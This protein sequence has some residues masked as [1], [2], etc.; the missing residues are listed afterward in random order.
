[1]LGVG[2]GGTHQTHALDSHC[3]LTWATAVL[4]GSPGRGCSV[5][6][7]NWASRDPGRKPRETAQVCSCLLS[8]SWGSY[9]GCRSSTTPSSQMEWNNSVHK[10]VLFYIFLWRRYIISMFSN[11]QVTEK[12]RLRTT[13]CQLWEGFILKLIGGTT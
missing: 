3:E 13:A 7:N 10:N 5:C 6:A 8:Y 9:R 2:M 4:Q 1:M 11:R 12:K